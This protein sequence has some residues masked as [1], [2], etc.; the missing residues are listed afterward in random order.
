MYALLLEFDLLYGQV[1]SLKEKRSL[2]RPPLAEIRRRWPVAAAE[3]A[4][5]ELLRRAGIGVA[6]VAESP[7]RCR[8]VG[9]EIERFIAGAPEST[10]LSV[11]RRWVGPDDD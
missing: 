4:D 5:M 7:D 10:L 1:G 6:M 2:L 8:Q 9:E 11:R 3:V